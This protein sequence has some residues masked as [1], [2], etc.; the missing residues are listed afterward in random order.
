MLINIYSSVTMIY[1]HNYYNYG[2]YQISCLLFQTRRFGDCILS[3][4]SGGTYSVELNSEDTKE[5][6]EK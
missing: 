6:T 2:N 5:Q 4:V 3:P 1:Y